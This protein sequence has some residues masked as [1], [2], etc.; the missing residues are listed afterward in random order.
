VFFYSQ[1]SNCSITLSNFGF[2]RT[3]TEFLIL[4]NEILLQ[5]TIISNILKGLTI[6]T[7][8]GAFET[9]KELSRLPAI[10]SINHLF[11]MYY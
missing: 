10:V 11:V 8:G 9:Q 4:L 1:S 5:V 7:A 6:I 2:L 3:N